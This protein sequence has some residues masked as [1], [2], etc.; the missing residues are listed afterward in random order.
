M[1]KPMIITKKLN[2]FGVLKMP[3]LFLLT[4]GQNPVDI[5]FGDMADLVVI[6]AKSKILSDDHKERIKKLTSDPK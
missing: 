4:V 6:C 2:K 5:Y 3:E 1:L